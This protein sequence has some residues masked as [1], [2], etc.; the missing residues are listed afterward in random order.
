MKPK[1]TQLL[2]M[3][4]DIYDLRF[5]RA[6]LEWDQSTYMPPKGNDARSRQIALLSELAHQKLCDPKIGELILACSEI[7]DLSEEDRALL[8]EIRR[9]H[10]RAIKVPATLV[11]ELSETCGQA[12]AVWIESRKKSSFKLYAPI[13]KK[14]IE[15]KYQEAQALGYGKGVPYD[16]LLDG[17]EPGATVKMLNPI[18][19]ETRKITTQAVQ[20]IAG[21]RRKPKIQILKRKYAISAQEQLNHLVLNQMGFDFGAGRLDRAVH[22]FSTSFDMDDSRITTRYQEKGFNDSLFSTIHE[23]GHAL[24]EQGLLK[25]HSGTPLAEAISMGIHESQSRFWE[26]QIGRNRQFWKFLFPKTRKLFP[27]ALNGVSLD[28]FYFAINAVQPSFIRVDADEVTYNLHV[29]LRYELEQALFSG[30]LQVGDLPVLW[31]EKMKTYLGIKPQKDSEG[32]LQDIHW[33]FGGFGYFPSY[34]LGNL[35]S[36]QWVSFM[37]KELKTFDHCLLKGN[38]LPIK[39][40]LNQNIHQHGRRF[41]AHELVHRVTGEELNPKYFDNYLRE[42]FQPLYDV[43][44]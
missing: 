29:I 30:D 7:S 6:V 2:Q 33:S 14:V 35:Y 23:G 12:Q 26:N 9:D 25:K 44:W 38:L 21:S 43:N 3:L 28:D 22:P 10:D 15:L 4:R 37:K 18:I 40:W 1:F 24:Y 16:A 8:R 5:A 11:R 17:F 32:V 31:N 13:L 39:K 41:P 20:A 36:V 19:A 34:L 27:Q 42:K